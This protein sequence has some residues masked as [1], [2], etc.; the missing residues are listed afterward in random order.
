MLPIERQNRI[1]ELILDKHNLKISELSKE[2]SVSEMTIHR[3]LKPLIETGIIM[4]TFGGIALITDAK[5]KDAHSQTCVL[6]SGNI[7]ERLAYRL[8][9]P[10]NT[11]EETC[12]AHCGLLR[13]RQLEGDLVQAICHD[14]FKR[15]TISAPLAWYVMDTSIHMGCCQPQVLTFQWKEHAEKFVKGFGGHV[16]SFT[17]GMEAVFQQMNGNHHHHCS[18]EL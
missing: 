16:Y 11:I 15:T 5:N 18:K 8:I 10:N 9:L 1:K 4:K 17:E 3:D 7:D 13:H 12:C 6:C 2:L 14:F